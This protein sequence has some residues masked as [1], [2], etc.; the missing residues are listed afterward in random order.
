MGVVMG[1]VVGHPQYPLENPGSA[2][3]A[4]KIEASK[5]HS[6][7]PYNVEKGRG[8]SHSNIQVLCMYP[9]YNKLLHVPV[10]PYL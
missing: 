8:E 4:H 3:A 1:V 10:K 2:T 9:E 7:P 5:H 6:E